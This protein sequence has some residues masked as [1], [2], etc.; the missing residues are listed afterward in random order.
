MASNGPTLG[1]TQATHNGRR[2]LIMTHSLYRRPRSI[3]F[4]DDDAD[5][6]ELLAHSVPPHWQA[7]FFTRPDDCVDRLRGE[8]THFK[9]DVWLQQSMVNRWH[10]GES[11]VRQLLGYWSADTSRYGLNG[12]LVIDYAMPARHGLQVLREL[13]GWPGARVLLT[14][15]AD[16][17]LAVQAFNEGLID[18]FIEKQAPDFAAQL[19]QALDT[20]QDNTT[21]RLAGIWHSTL[22]ARQQAVLGQ[23]GVASRLLRIAR[24]AGWVE[25]GVLGDPFG[26]LALDAEGQ[27]WWL[28][29]DFS[30]GAPTRELSDLPLQTT[31]GVHQTPRLARAF[32]SGRKR[33][34]APRSSA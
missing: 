29:L 15:Q 33:N 25:H 22:N 11:L 32:R 4:L 5:F 1:V 8:L 21:R 2:A 27:A 31:L 23:P 3:V 10:R 16:T 18:K 7:S 34:C 9:A 17:Q 6:L 30:S 19:T 14:G 28:Q 20:L 24:R 12:V 26:M 13:D